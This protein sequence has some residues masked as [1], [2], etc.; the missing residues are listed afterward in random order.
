MIPYNWLFEA[1][2]KI[3][4]YA[5]L[6][7]L[8]Y[9]PENLI[10]IK[11]ENHQV[12]GS[13]KA[14]SAINKVL[15]LQNWELRRSIVTASAGNHGQGVALAG[16][17]ANSTVIVYAS[18]H[19]V[20]EK[21]AA[22]AELGA[23]IWLVDGGFDKAEETGRTFAQKDDMTWISPY[24]DGRIIAGQGTFGV[25]VLNDPSYRDRHNK[26][27]WI[28]P[29]S[30]GGLVSSL[31]IALKSHEP[32]LGQINIV[33]VQSEMSAFM[34]SIFHRGTQENVADL[35]SIADGLSGAVERNSV[36]IPIV[37]KYVDDLIL[38]TER[39]IADEILFAWYSY[40]EVVEGA[41]A[42]ALDAVISGKIS[43]SPVVIILS[44]G[45]IPSSLHQRIINREWTTEE[46]IEN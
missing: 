44:G 2:I 32:T 15:S 28:V 43:D 13:F 16:Q 1:Q 8:T 19:A 37:K 20:R 12:T 38:V 40:N 9:D 26:I 45:N 33:G 34:D 7:P 10:Y 24:N 21:L 4:P 29:T 5:P 22:I 3:S 27:T 46:L 23:E 42:T 31:C 6:T 39:E 18:K 36:T 41:A 14:S 11:W 30:G 35:P 25:K 17:I